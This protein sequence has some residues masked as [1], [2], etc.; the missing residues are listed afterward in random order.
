[1]NTSVIQIILLLSISSH[2]FCY[3]RLNTIYRLFLHWTSFKTIKIICGHFLDVPS[4]YLSWE[5]IFHD[6]ARVKFVRAICKI[7]F[8]KVSKIFKT[9]VFLVWLRR[10]AGDITF[11]SIKWTVAIKSGFVF[12]QA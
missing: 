5:C 4:K 2:A 11:R 10:S 8:C 6:R 3:P 7:D 1:M 12:E 9:N